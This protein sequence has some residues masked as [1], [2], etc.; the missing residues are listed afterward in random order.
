[1]KQSVLYN[2]VRSRQLEGTYPGSG[3]TGVWPISALRIAY[4]WG[5]PD[6][7]D[8]PYEAIQHSWPP[9]EPPGLDKLAKKH[10]IR[11]YQRVNSLRNIKRVMAVHGIPVSVSIQITD[12]W[13]G[14]KDG[15][16]IIP[17]DKYPPTIFHEVVVVGYDNAKS[18]LIIR[19]SW[20]KVWGDRGHGLLP[21]EYA[22]KYI[23][24]GW[25][26]FPTP[27]ERNEPLKRR[28]VEK[29]WG[30]LRSHWRYFTWF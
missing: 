3:S 27:E 11:A 30:L 18:L 24:E 12:Q 9:P 7:A 6:E 14:T 20:G 13:Y 1:M 17:S 23:R 25:A 16:L 8:W 5:S 29:V 26:I 15:L 22:I 19:N 4:G 2:Y 10:R 28:R 21:Y